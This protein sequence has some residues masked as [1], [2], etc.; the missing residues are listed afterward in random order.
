MKL[1]PSAFIRPHTTHPMETHMTMKHRFSTAIVAAAAS[2]VPALAAAQAYPSKPVRW[3]VPFPAGGGA[4]VLARTVAKGLSDKWGQQVVVDNKPGGLTLIGAVEAVKAPADGY[5][6]FQPID[7]TLTMNQFMFSKP[8]YDP[9]RDF[10]HITQLAWATFA[11]FSHPATP[12]KSVKDVLALAK[13]KPGEVTFGSGTITAQ[14]AGELLARDGGIKLTHVPYKGTADVLKA[15]MGEEVTI[16][17][18]VVTPYMSYLQA[19]KLRV[20]ATTGKQRSGAMPD[21]PTLKELGYAHSIIA[22]WH[23]LSAPAGLPKDVADKIRRDVAEV[24]Q[25]PEVKAKLLSVGFDVASSSAESYVEL[26]KADS[27]RMEPIIRELG[28]KAD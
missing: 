26:I 13:A 11:V 9:L 27:A 1:L 16:S 21:V 22:P 17:I 25:Q 14:L 18:D 20:L 2:M 7:S 28:L 15:T 6:L 24:L 8:R 19:G 5:T 4:D 10:T 23:G 12:V 3:I